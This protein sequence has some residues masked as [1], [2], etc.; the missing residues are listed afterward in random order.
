MRF[1]TV[2]IAFV[3]VA[4]ASPLPSNTASGLTIPVPVAQ[5]AF[6]HT[7]LD[8]IRRDVQPESG[9]VIVARSAQKTQL[10]GFG[11]IKK[12]IKM[13][14]KLLRLNSESK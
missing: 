6:A 3:A 5:N 13:P 11:M 1:S 2:L 12:V 7:Q 9:S 10:F 8:V 14:F 4:S